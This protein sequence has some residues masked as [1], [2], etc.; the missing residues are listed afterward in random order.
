MLLLYLIRKDSFFF[1]I[2]NYKAN[3]VSKLETYDYRHYIT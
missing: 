3:F 2:K 1:I